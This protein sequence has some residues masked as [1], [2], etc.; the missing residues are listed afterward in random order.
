MPFVFLEHYHLPKQELKMEKKKSSGE[1]NKY[2]LIIFV[3]G[4]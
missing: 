3:H 4:Y 2:H 1:K